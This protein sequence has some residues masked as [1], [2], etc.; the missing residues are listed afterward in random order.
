MV[1]D[2]ELER[3]FR[4]MVAVKYGLKKGALSKA[5]EEAIKLWIEKHS[6]V[7]RSD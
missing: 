1:I 6:V 5:V 4:K 3:K 7:T 2:D